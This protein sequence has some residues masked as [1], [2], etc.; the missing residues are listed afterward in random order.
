MS[1]SQ[2]DLQREPGVPQD[3][4]ERLLRHA[5][6]SPGGET[7]PHTGPWTPPVDLFEDA[8]SIVLRVDVPG[9]NP[10]DVELRFLDGTLTIR[11][12]RGMPE[13]AKP[14]TP[15][16]AERP[17]GTFVRTFGLPTN[18]DPAG[19]RATQR[20]G[21]LEIVLAKKKESKG[22]SIRIEVR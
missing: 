16:R 13:E 22:R 14:G 20:N 15:L 11:G 4:V 9:V 21:V 5:A 3:R 19:I 18:V 7:L 8:E 1:V 2:W 6:G 17:C 10:D 12:Q